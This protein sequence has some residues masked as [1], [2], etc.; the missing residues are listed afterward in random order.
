MQKSLT[1]RRVG[2]FVKQFYEG[3]L[4]PHLRSAEVPPEPEQPGLVRDVVGSTFEQF[5]TGDSAPE[6]VLIQLYSPYNNNCRVLAPYA[7]TS[8]HLPFSL[9]FSPPPPRHPHTLACCLR[10]GMLCSAISSTSRSLCSCVR[11]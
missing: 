7:A 1:A 2:L 10:S 6:H 11:H 5:V 4:R 8:I 9:R 3:K